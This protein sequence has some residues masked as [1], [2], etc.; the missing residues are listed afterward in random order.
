[1]GI[2]RVYQVPKDRPRAPTAAAPSTATPTAEAHAD[3]DGAERLGHRAA[4]L[5]GEA[6][7]VPMDDEKD[8]EKNEELMGELV[9]V[10]Y[11]HRSRSRTRVQAPRWR[12]LI[13]AEGSARPRA[14]DLL[15]R[16]AAPFVPFVA[17]RAQSVSNVHETATAKSGMAQ[18]GGP[19][20]RMISVNI[21]DE[22]GEELLR[23]E[24]AEPE[25]LGAVSVRSAC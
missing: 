18:A 20:E 13:G 22:A 8:D 17:C 9:Q 16:Y 4:A 3:S 15:I 19:P 7:D 12:R 21:D 24:P 1:L 10:A 11:P 14:V 2:V 6:D 25:V 5:E 23:G